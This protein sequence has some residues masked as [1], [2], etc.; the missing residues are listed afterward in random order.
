MLSDVDVYGLGGVVAFTLS[1]LAWA[2]KDSED[3]IES[4]A[5]GSVDKPSI[6]K[7][8]RKLFKRPQS[9]TFAHRA[10]DRASCAHVGQL[11]YSGFAL[12]ERAESL[13]SFQAYQECPRCEKV[14]FHG[15][16]T[17][18]ARSTLFRQC[19]FCKYYWRQS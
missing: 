2:Y 16:K 5:N 7:P 14:D 4:I 11:R 3:F 19:N 15:I 8:H 9:L 6:R 1:S 12:A 10:V 18:A 17:L 13:N